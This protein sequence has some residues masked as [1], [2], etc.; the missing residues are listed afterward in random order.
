LTWFWAIL[1]V[2]VS[3]IW[4]GADTGRPLMTRFDFGDVCPPR[5]ASATLNRAGLVIDYGNGTVET[6]CVEFAEETINGWELLQRAGPQAEQ[7]GG[8]VCNIKGVGC[9]VSDCACECKNPPP[10]LYWSYWVKSS[11]GE[12]G[13]SYSNTGA[14]LRQV[15]DGYVDGWHWGVAA[16]PPNCSHE[17]VCGSTDPVGPVVLPVH[18]SPGAATGDVTP[19]FTWTAAWDCQ[20]NVAG[21]N[22]EVTGT[23]KTYTTTNTY[24]DWPTPLSE[25]LHG[26]R[27]RA[28]DASGNYSAWTDYKQFGVDT[29]P[30]TPVTL[31]WP[32]DGAF[33]DADNLAFDWSDSTDPPKNGYSSGV[34]GY[35]LEITG[36]GGATYTTTVPALAQSARIEATVASSFTP[37]TPIDDGH[38]GWRVRALD[39]GLNPSAWSP[40]R[41]LTVDGPPHAFDLIAP[42]SGTAVYTRTPTLTWQPSADPVAGLKH[43]RVEIGSASWQLITVA[44]D[45]TATTPLTPLSSGTYTWTVYA[46]DNTGHSRQ[47][48]ETRNFKIQLETYLPVVMK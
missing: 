6:Y 9:P 12:G 21:Y 1:A 24:Y 34:A 25:G 38:H 5:Q 43:Y 39:A 20:S 17:E 31:Q 30:P 19:R 15:Y 29:Q 32:A 3:G 2:I 35:N 36:T 44:A 28:Y 41:Y 8:F 45:V 47:A 33:L 40:Y 18:Q 11:P 42:L 23:T 22:V 7:Y 13:W 27:L 10:C 4:P 46:L 48:N 26:W 37:T 14:W 16:K